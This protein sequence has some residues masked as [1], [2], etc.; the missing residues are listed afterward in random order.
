MNT[1]HHKTKCSESRRSNTSSM[2]T[3]QLLASANASAAAALADTTVDEA[4]AA[5]DAPVDIGTVFSSW[6]EAL[7]AI[8]SLALQMGRR[9]MAEKAEPMTWCGKPVMA[10]RILTIPS[11]GVCIVAGE[12][13]GAYEMVYRVGQAWWCS[14][15]RNP[16]FCSHSEHG[17]LR[18]LAE[19][20]HHAK[21]MFCVR[22]LLEK[23]ARDKNIPALGPLEEKVWELQRQETEEAFLRVF[24]VLEGFNTAAAAF[25]RSV[26]PKNWAYYPN[27]SIKLYGWATT[28]A[29]EAV[30]GSD[31]QRSDEAPFDLIYM[32]L[33]FLM[34]GIYKKSQVA[35]KLVPVD[36]QR[37]ILLTPGADTVYRQEREAATEYTVRRCDEQ[38]AFAWLTG[39]RPKI[40]YR[41]DFALRTCTCGQMFQLGWPCRHFIAASMHFANEAVLLDSFDPIYKATAYVE[42]H[43]NLRIEIPV[44]GDLH[45]DQSLLPA[46]RPRSTKYKKRPRSGGGNNG[47]VVDETSTAMM[48]SAPS[49]ISVS[50]EVSSAPLAKTPRLEFDSDV[51][52]SLGEI[53]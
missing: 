5:M 46:T 4:A 12:R 3:D 31:I 28:G 45:K 37:S 14:F 18:A 39:A 41:M 19:E 22:S 16:V 49:A 8:R 40:T 7:A 36:G 20:A 47:N 30:T 25:L 53:V 9:V 1:V 29:E 11:I 48:S 38:V 52:N 26:H 10:R 32:F 24:G 33:A 34:D 43:R 2:A 13:L 15:R 44:A 21:I 42:A 23:M 6:K 17:L 27:R 50:N 35:S 51:V